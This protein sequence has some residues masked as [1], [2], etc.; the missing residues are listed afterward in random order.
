MTVIIDD[1][2]RMDYERVKGHI[3]LP[4]KII[5]EGSTD[6]DKI[7]FLYDTGAYLTVINRDRYEWFGLHRLPRKKVTIQPPSH[8]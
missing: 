1:K 2:T 4:I 7:D 3:Y 5:C 6:E 8:M